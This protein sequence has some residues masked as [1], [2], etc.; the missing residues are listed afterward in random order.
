MLEGNVDA[1]GGLKTFEVS[2]EFEMM[3]RGLFL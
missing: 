2:H 1:L 3:I